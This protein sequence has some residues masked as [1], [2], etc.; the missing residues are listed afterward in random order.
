MDGG[1]VWERFI[2]SDG[3]TFETKMSCSCF[4]FHRILASKTFT[5]ISLAKYI[6]NPKS[7]GSGL[8][9]RWF[10]QQLRVLSLKFL[11]PF[12]WTNVKQKNNKTKTRTKDV[13][14]EPMSGTSSSKNVGGWATTLN[15]QEC[16]RV[17]EA[18]F[19][20]WSKKRR[21]GDDALSSYTCLVVGI[22]NE[23]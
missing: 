20:E 1:I 2:V 23:K 12:P 5:F 16:R 14:F 17:Q 9:K 22:P 8:W 13:A 21:S 10:K 6:G 3:W 18:G 7:R 19:S 11:S 4:L 15:Q